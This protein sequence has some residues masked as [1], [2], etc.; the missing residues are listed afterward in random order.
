MNSYSQKM[1]DAIKEND[2]V[3]AQL[4]FENA[5]REDQPEFLVELGEQLFALGFL[6]EAQEVFEQ[7][8]TLFPEEA[9]LLITLAEIAI[10]N[11][12]L[13]TAFN[14]L[15]KI[16]KDDPSYVESLLVT[17]DIY[18]IMGVPE[19]SEKKI[20]EAQKLMPGEPVL[21]L[22]LAELLFVNDKFLEAIRLYEQL[23]N[24][25]LE[26]MAH[27]DLYDRLGTSLSM[28]GEFEEAIPYLEKSLEEEQTDHVLFRLGVTYIQLGEREKAITYLEQL[29]L[30]N[31]TYETLYL[32]LASALLDEN[33][34]LEA[35]KVMAEGLAQNP[36][37][38]DLYHLASD[39]AFRLGKQADAEEYMR[40]AISLEEDKEFSM[41]KLANLLLVEE[42]FEEVVDTL[43]EF[44][45]QDQPQAHWSLAKAY[46]GLE[47]FKQAG[48]HYEKAFEGLKEEPEFL[49]D[50]GIYLREEGQNDQAQLV[51]EA[52][53]LHVPDDT[54]VYDL[55]ER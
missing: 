10:E 32:P 50:Y 17:A 25:D 52:Y 11:D 54:E 51:L 41:I 31:P 46:N 37:S 14:Y 30:L 28:I 4:A 9:S 44:A 49:K 47:D 2:L 34:H 6:E 3:E 18:Q 12:E 55:L 53:L 7:L 40:K 22:A 24:Q 23:L 36:Y 1:L 19:V 45:S 38:V 48:L 15:E 8:V 43:S 42:R 33:Q 21:D 13:E 27:I 16:A 35:E 29:R 5:L 26:Q 39:N 20:K